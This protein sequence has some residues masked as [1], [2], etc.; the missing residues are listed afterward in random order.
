MQRLVRG[1]DELRLRIDPRDGGSYRVF[2]STRSAEASTGFELPFDAPEIENFILSVSRPR[3]RHRSDPSAVDDARRFGGGLFEALFHGQICALYRDALA[4]ARSQDRGVRITL[5]LSGSPELI[6]VPWEYLFDDPDFLAVSAFTPVVRYLDLPRAHRPLLVEPPL[7][8]LGVV[9]SPAE[10]EQ[11]DAE[12]ERDNLERALSGLSDAGAVELHWLERPTLGALL[13]ALQTQTFHA[14]HFIGHGAYDR[15]AGRGVLLFEDD[16]GWARPVSG[17]KL[18]MILHD[19]SSLR[20]AILNA[21][22]GA[23]TARTDPFAGVAGSLVQQ[24]IPAVVAMQ[25][26]ISDEAAIVFAGDFY[27]QL[28]AG[29]PVDASLAA[30]RLAMLAERSDDIEWGTP[31]LFMRVPDGRIFDLDGHNEAKVP[32]PSPSRTRS[33]GSIAATTARSTRTVFVNYRR[34][35][36]SGHALL[37]TDRLRQHFGIDDVHLADDHGSEI[38]RLAQAPGTG[39]LLVLIGPGWISSLKSVSADRHTEDFVRHQ[40]EWALRSRPHSVIPVLVDAAMPDPEALPRSLRGLCRKDWSE[41]RHGSFDRDIDSLVERV[42]RVGGATP[43][44]PTATRRRTALSIGSG[45]VTAQPQRSQVA[46]GVPEP[47]GDHYL[48]V[49]RGMLDGTV[50]PL[51]GSGFRGTLPTADHLATPLADQFATQSSGLAAVAQRV[52]VTL[53]ERRLYAAIKDLVAAQSEPNEVHVFLASFPGLLRQLGLRPRH[54]LIINANYD[55]ALERAFEEANEPFD[56][57]V[58]LADSGWFV[59]VPWG[60]RTAE[61]IATTILEPRRYVGF[62]IDDDGELERT[63]IVKIH[64]GADG[65]EGGVAWRN[66]Y[67]VTEDHYIDYLPTQNISDHLPIQILDKLTGSR[68]LFLGYPL[69]D[70]NT[71]VFLRRIWRGR[72]ISESSWAIERSPDLLEKASWSV[73]GHVELLAAG[74]EDYVDALR[75]TLLNWPG[76]R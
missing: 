19:F 65:H 30:A 47:Y 59:H 15:E 2:A 64:G 12:R 1:Y 22:E 46:G 70:W 29:S 54:Q 44:S 50:V 40:I 52:A 53:G 16:S 69:G 24:D 32:T 39:V 10:H 21:C 67:V 8:L 14:L 17:D 3:G 76:E 20:L 71:R 68:C 26:E 4:Q 75:S 49:I 55:S 11:L 38:D 56:Y 73:I 63:I 72:P 33:A 60:E 58:Y 23:R 34:G 13:K 31:V 62:P 9:S 45:P 74:L 41:L 37:L 48:D 42:E 18:G 43:A 36:T 35:D 66:N 61:P 28:A 57:A 51:L 27:R 25:F 6:D 7:R 5:C